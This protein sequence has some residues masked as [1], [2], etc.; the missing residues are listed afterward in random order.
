MNTATQKKKSILIWGR[1]IQDEAHKILQ[2]DSTQTIDHIQ[3]CFR[4]KLP[5]GRHTRPPYFLSLEALKLR[6][7]QLHFFKRNH[8]FFFM[9]LL[10]ISRRIQRPTT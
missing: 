2:S 10:P 8:I 4:Q 5:E 9:T 1:D 7:G 3:K 6:R